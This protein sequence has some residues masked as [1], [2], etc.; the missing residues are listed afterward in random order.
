M[1]CW[2]LTPTNR[3]WEPTEFRT[4]FHLP[5][6]PFCISGQRGWAEHLCPFT[7][8]PASSCQLG[9]P[10]VWSFPNI[11]TPLGNGRSHQTA[12]SL[13]VHE[14]LFWESESHRPTRARL[15][16]TR[17]S[18]AN[19]S[20]APEPRVTGLSFVYKSLG[21][22]CSWQ[23]NRSVPTPPYSSVLALMSEKYKPASLFIV[24]SMGHPRPPTVKRGK[25]SCDKAKRLNSTRP[26]NVTVSK[27]FSI[28]Q[29]N[30]GII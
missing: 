6:C 10:M 8:L 30:A 22:F 1:L 27:S 16:R 11:Q 3:W 24:E 12:L 19:Q 13:I 7:G 29:V 20:S 18:T 15:L 17:S 14:S 26:F 25:V 21:S 23:L 2:L 28:T 9:N 5:S 4:D